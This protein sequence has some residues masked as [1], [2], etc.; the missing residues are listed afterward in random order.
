MTSDLIKQ[1]KDVYSTQ[2]LLQV[3]A[4]FK[5]MMNTL[6]PANGHPGPAIVYFQTLFTKLSQAQYA[7]PDNI[8]AMIVLSHLPTTM[9][10][11]M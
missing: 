11:I 1:L 9:S 3:F 7:I 5:V 4:D 6:I 2:G 8:Q 10:V